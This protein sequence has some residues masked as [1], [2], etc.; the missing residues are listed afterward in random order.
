M[1]GVTGAGG[2]LAREGAASPSP[3]VIAAATG[4][5]PKR[6]ASMM[7]FRFGQGAGGAVGESSTDGE[8]AAIVPPQ[9]S[10]V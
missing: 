3:A 10:K 2:A 9:H 7:Q 8:P 1:R 5:G 4:G 6:S